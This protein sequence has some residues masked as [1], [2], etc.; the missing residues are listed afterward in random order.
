MKWTRLLLTASLL[1]ACADAVELIPKVT[2]DGKVYQDV[3]WGPVNQGKVVMF[4]SRGNTTVPLSSL[5]KEYQEQL[6]YQPPPPPPPTVTPPVTPPP[7]VPVEPPKVVTPPPVPL[8]PPRDADWETYS[9]ER[10]TKL[11][12]ND[13]L[14]NRSNLSTVVGFLES[15]VRI[16]TDSVK[17]RGILMEVAEKKTDVTQ[18]ADELSLRPNLWERTGKMVLLRNYKADGER[19]VLV[20]LFV[21]PA[22]DLD[23]H[24]TYEVGIEPTFEQW[25]QLR[26][27]TIRTP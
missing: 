16:Y 22:A 5:P 15:P 12:L 11:V 13:K 6:G 25:K 26:F 3:R 2:I 1:A 10:K 27:N 20:R 17:V 4:H 7:T 9:R 19:G 18:P 23:G 8:P 14:V 21:A 24:N